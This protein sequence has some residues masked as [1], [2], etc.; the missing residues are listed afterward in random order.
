MIRV[1]FVCSGNI[2]RSPMAEGIFR[3]MLR[4]RGL[5]AEFEVDSAGVGAWHVGEGADPRAQ[6]VLRRHGADF[7]HIARQ[8]EPQ[9]QAY[10]HIFAMGDQCFPRRYTASLSK[11]YCPRPVR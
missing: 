5:E 7:P 2:C 3:R 11:S 10:D 8:L 4:E 9:D 6:E 1:L